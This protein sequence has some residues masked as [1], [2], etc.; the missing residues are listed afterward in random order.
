LLLVGRRNTSSKGTTAQ[1]LSM[2]L[3]DNEELPSASNADPAGGSPG[4]VN[5][6]DED[7]D[8]HALSARILSAH[9]KGR[10]KHGERRVKQ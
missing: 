6:D 5:G 1:I 4:S 7:Q 10:K 9:P 2:P 3:N 8:Q